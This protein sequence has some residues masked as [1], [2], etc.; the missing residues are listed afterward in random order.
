MNQNVTAIPYQ[1]GSASTERRIRDVLE[2]ADSDL[3]RFLLGE[4]DEEPESVLENAQTIAQLLAH[5]ANSAKDSR[6][7]DAIE[8]ELAG[9][10]GFLLT[11]Q[12]EMARAMI[13][14][15]E[16]RRDLESW[17]NFDTRE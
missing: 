1:K 7:G 14:H 9:R 10:V 4:C 3:A 12:L 6:G 11:Q 5:V 17:Q 16:A 13:R 8:P 2:P 15:G